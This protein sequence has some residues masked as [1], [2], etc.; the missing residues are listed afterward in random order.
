MFARCNSSSS[1]LPLAFRQ[2]TL[3]ALVVSSGRIVTLLRPKKHTIHPSDL[4][5]LLCHLPDP[6]S[7]ATATSDA[8]WIP[9][10][11]PRFNPRGFLH[12][13][14]SWATERTCVVMVCGDREAVAKA[15]EWG[16][17]VKERV[18]AT[19]KDGKKGKQDLGSLLERVERGR[20][21]QVYSLGEWARGL[22]RRGG[23]ASGG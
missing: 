1:F 20:V 17:G 13:Y 6:S 8:S 14:V 16:E 22:L 4:H 12:A 2:D 7:S 11:L 15:R 23:G 10:C 3:Y 21:G 5:L 9:I 19:A 18:T